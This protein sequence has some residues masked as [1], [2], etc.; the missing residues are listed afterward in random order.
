MKKFLFGLGLVFV[1]A[2]FQ[3]GSYR[4]SLYTMQGTVDNRTVILE[5]GHMYDIN[6]IYKDGQNVTVTL[7]NVGNDINLKNDTIEKIVVDNQ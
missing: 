4:T 2:L 7:R 3:F 6:G 5:N 1:I